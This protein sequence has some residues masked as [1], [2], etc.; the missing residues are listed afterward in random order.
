MVTR[1]ERPVVESKEKKG[2]YRNKSPLQDDEKA[3]TLIKEALKVPVNVTIEDLLNIAEA[4][5]QEL[6]KLL[7]KKRECLL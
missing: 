4:A 1:E 7:T 2:V 5:R 6:K 3:I